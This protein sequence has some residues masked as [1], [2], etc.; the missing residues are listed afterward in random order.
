MTADPQAGERAGGVSVSIRGVR[1]VFAQRQGVVRA[2]WNFDL[3]IPAGQFVSVVG[4][5]GCGKT[6]ILTMVGGLVA[7]RV[8]TVMLDGKAVKGPP[9][10][11]AYM[12]ARD[13][14]MPWRTAQQNI[15]FGLQI[16]GVRRDERRA[17]ALEWLERVGLSGFGSARVGELSQGMRQRVAIARTLALKPRCLL[18]DEPFASLDAQTRMIIQQEFLRLWESVNATVI[19][20]THDLAEATLLGDRVVLVSSR[21]GRVVE[22]VLVEMARPRAAEAEYEDPAFQRYYR[23]LSGRLRE[24]VQKQL[25]VPAVAGRT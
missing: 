17:A 10:D 18:M 5:S 9:R 2:L 24:E 21:P 4:P 15:E 8:G 25:A 23:R 19:F 11:V 16:R 12:L 14:L 7:P 22:D 6:T 1:H 20:V 13:A 3:D